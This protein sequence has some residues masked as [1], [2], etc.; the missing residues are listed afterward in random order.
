MASAPERPEGLATYSVRTVGRRDRE[1]G[2]FNS[3]GDRV[4]RRR[5]NQ[6]GDLEVY[7]SDGL[8]EVFP[9]AETDQQ[10]DEE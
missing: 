4:P 9:N 7:R 3:Q 10:E 8:V 5:I 2:Y 6:N 1:S